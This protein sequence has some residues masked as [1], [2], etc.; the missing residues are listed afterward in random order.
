MKIDG[1]RILVTG[2]AGF[3]GSQLTEKLVR[4][5]ATVTAVDN[6]QTGRIEN[7]N[8]CLSD[9]EFIELDIRDFEGVQRHGRHRDAIVNLAA[10]ASVPKSIDSP[11][12]DF[13][14]NAGG[15][16]SILET[17][18]LC[19]IRHVVQASSA[20]VYGLPEYLPIDEKHPLRPV[21][22]YGASKLSAE[23]LGNTFEATYHQTFSPLRIFNAYGGRQRKHVIYDLLSQIPA[24][25]RTIR[26]MGHRDHIRDFI[27]V[28]DVTNSFIALIEHLDNSGIVCNSGTGRPTRISELVEIALRSSGISDHRVEFTNRSWPG[29]VPSLLSDTSR[30]NG[31]LGI[32]AGTTIEK[33]IAALVNDRQKFTTVT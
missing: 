17:A 33:G 27:H 26:M 14:I 7:L 1:S 18:R 32:N 5:G 3:I 11:K 2:A 10:N 22:P 13:D 28:D 20:A 15:M 23:I 30:M 12:A 19:G 21:S 16:V 31:I 8:D 4:L 6:L 9:I 24:P 25:Q 29:D